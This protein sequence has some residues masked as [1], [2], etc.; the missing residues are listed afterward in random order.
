MFIFDVETL[1]NK[2]N[3][4]I[5]SMAC[6]HFDDSESDANDLPKQYRK[7]LDSA[8][9][10][11]FDAN[12]QVKRFGRSI[13]KS[14]VDWWAKQCDHAKIKSFIPNSTDVKIEDGIKQMKIWANKFNDGKAWVWARGGL[15][16]MVL[17][18][19]EETLDFEPTFH[20]SRWRDVR[21]AVDFL[22]GSTNGYCNIPKFDSHAYVVKHDPIHDCAYDVMMLLYGK[23]K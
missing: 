21:T 15:D 13:S 6:I 10:V 7:F 17:D 9:F 4:V 16:Q 11:K 2:S 23:N 22:T 18:S 20:F 8:F 19:F 14:T 12:D 3:S 5:L 1:D